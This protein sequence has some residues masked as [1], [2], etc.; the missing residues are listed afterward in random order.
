MI[1]IHKTWANN[2]ISKGKGQNQGT[3]HFESAKYSMLDERHNVTASMA[4][5]LE[6][7]Q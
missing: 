5:W 4:E 3:L 7:W 6:F 2:V 1:N